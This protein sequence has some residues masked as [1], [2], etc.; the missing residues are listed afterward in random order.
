MTRWKRSVNDWLTRLT[1]Y[2]LVRARRAGESRGTSEQFPA[3]YD[4]SYREIIRAVRP[5][6]M[7]SN[8]KLHVLI[9][10][11]RYIQLHRIPGAIV[12]C[13]VW[14]VAACTPSLGRWTN[15]ATTLGNLSLRHL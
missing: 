11:T 1:G 3:D 13:G 9:T 12:E 5:F 14:R 10:A 4:E 7:T 2:Q 6:T 8:D 15:S